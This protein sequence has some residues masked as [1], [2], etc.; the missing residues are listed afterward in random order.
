M[1]AGS[2]ERKTMKKTIK[3]CDR[4]SEQATCHA[5]NRKVHIDNYGRCLDRNNFLENPLLCR[6]CKKPFNVGEQLDLI[7]NQTI[8]YEF[9]CECGISIKVPSTD[10]ANA[11]YMYRQ[12]SGMNDFK[13]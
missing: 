7:T 8:G 11:M 3:E 1:R 13:V 2:F 5:E 9:S 6:I 4:C 12:I 10:M